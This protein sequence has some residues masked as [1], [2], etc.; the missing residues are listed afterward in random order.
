MNRQLNDE[1]NRASPGG[2]DPRH[3]SNVSV[4]G[5]LMKGP[6]SPSEPNPRFPQKNI[7]HAPPTGG[8][9]P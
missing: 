8:R 5:S 1:P 7:K 2:P 6:V 3:R 4:W 9:R